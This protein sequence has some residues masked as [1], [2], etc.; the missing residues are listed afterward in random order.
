M[1]TRLFVV[2]IFVV[3]SAQWQYVNGQSMPVGQMSRQVDKNSVANFTAALDQE[4]QKTD[5]TAADANTILNA[6]ASAENVKAAAK[7]AGSANLSDETTKEQANAA[8]AN[9]QPAPCGQTGKPTYEF[10]YWFPLVR[11]SPDAMLYFFKTSGAIS[12]INTV[13]YLYNPNQST[14][15]VSADFF[16]ATFPLGFQSIFS[17]TATAGSSQPASTAPSTSSTESVSTAVSRLE[18]GGDFNVRFP[19]YLFFHATGSYGAYILSSPSVG[20]DVSGLSGQ[21]TIT[22]STEY[23]VNVPLE[24]YAQTGS[25]EQTAGVSNALLYVDVKPAME[26][27]SPGFASA[28]GLTSNRYFFLGQADVGI[29]FSK[30]VRVGFQYFFGPNQV[31]QVPGAAGTTATTKSKVGGVHLVISFSPPKSKS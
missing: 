29:E 31:Y 22:Q 11:C 14:N 25:I 6:S 16:T 13:Q 1:K 3:A 15:Q 26:L 10:K 24:F 7:A 23:N 19:Y 9:A 30:S 5:V 2:W 8:I 18:Q 20:F 17:G 4:L 12:T 28:I 27:V 21:N